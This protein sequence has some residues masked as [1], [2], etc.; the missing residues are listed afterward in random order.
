MLQGHPHLS[1]RTGRRKGFPSPRIRL[2]GEEARIA[3]NGLAFPLFWKKDGWVGP[4]VR[5]EGRAHGRHAQ[6]PRLQE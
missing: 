1:H 4:R 6:P 2:R 5:R 3:G